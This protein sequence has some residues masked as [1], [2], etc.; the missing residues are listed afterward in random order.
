MRR[1]SSLASI[2]SLVIFLAGCKSGTAGRVISVSVTPTAVNVVTGATLQ[3]TA[4]VTDTSNQAV[5]WSV[6]GSASGT[7]S[8]TGLYTA[9]GS[10]PTPAQ[11]TITDISQ[12]DTTKSGAATVTVTTTPTPSSV[13]VVVSPSAP[14]VANFVTQQF[15]ATVAGSTNTAG[16]WAVKGT[17]GG[18]RKL[19]FISAAGLYVAPGGVPTT[20]NGSTGAITTTL[21][22]T[23]VS[24]ADSR[25]SGSA[26]VTVVPGN[27]SSQTGAIELGT[28]GSNANDSNTSGQ[29]I[30]CCGGTLG[31]LV[32]RGGTQFILSNN[33]VLA[34]S[35]AG[36]VG[37][38]ITQPGLIDANCDKTQATAVGNL[39][40]FVNLES[41]SHTASATNID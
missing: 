20:A 6:A 5:K 13:S 34:R 40:Q 30:T 37:D 29:T 38:A 16:T 9:P 2:A 39:T 36:S 7:I 10:V 28:S 31:S 35:D 17:I 22:V 4:A 41:E 15:T 3:F 19:G 21:T 27:Q 24:Q 32:T 8:A 1:A 14:N 11:V 18:S 26:T 12:K 33:H 25:S 23:A